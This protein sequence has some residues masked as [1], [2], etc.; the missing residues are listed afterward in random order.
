[1]SAKPGFGSKVTA[2]RVSALIL[3]LALACSSGA[4]TA[5]YTLDGGTAAFTNQTFASSLTNQSAV[6]VKNSGRL[7]LIDGIVTSSGNTT[8]TDASSQYGLNASLLVN[9]AGKVAM[10]G[11]SITSTG[12]GANLAFA[13]G[14]GS[15]ICLTHATLTATGQNAHAVDVTYG[16]VIV[17]SNVTMVTRGG[18]SSAIATDYG[19]GTVT[20]VNCQAT[21]SGTKSAAIYSTGLISAYNSVCIS[22]NDYGGVID[23][24][25]SIVLSNTVMTG[26]SGGIQIHR[27]APGTGTATVT[28]YG[29]SV[30]ATSGNSFDALGENAATLLNLTLRSGTQLSNSTGVILSVT[31][32]STVSFVA[33]G[34]TLAG[35]IVASAANTNTVY[36]S[37]QNGTALTGFINSAKRLTIDAT[38]TWHATSNSVVNVLTNS[39]TI[40]LSGSLTATNVI[41]KSG[42]VFGGSGTLS[43]NLTVNAG[44]TLV[45]NPATN[46]TVS[47]SVIFGG[48]V[49]V[50]PS[51][52]NISAG[53]YRLLTYHST[54]SGSPVFTY[55]A[56]GGSGQT[57]TVDTA[58]AGV[59]TVT[60][61]APNTH[62]TLAAVS[63]RVITAGARL[64][65][66]NVATDADIPAQTLT[67]GLIAAPTNATLDATSGVLA[68][69]PLISQAYTTN[70][71]AVCVADSGSPSLSATQSF[72]VVV[73][74][75]AQPTNAGVSFAAGACQIQICGNLGPDYIIQAASNLVNASWITIGTTNPASM[76]FVWTDLTTG[77]VPSRFYR[78]RLG[79]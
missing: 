48:A 53:T 1:M 16:G 78:V 14:S 61:S 54:L 25:N 70:T 57:A 15:A 34:E 75:A 26:K 56:P 63:N 74:A 65:V 67:F 20:V 38:S 30:T 10:T 72:T 55:S 79:P 40:N 28:V 43:S 76:P 46:F 73:S 31:N 22:S 19:G 44:A 69:R 71:F 51:A 6:L 59:I 3:T 68:W 49:T 21:V 52:T 50:A 27:T 9:S 64:S 77:N 17:A 8:N 4:Q 5:T 39:G 66:T 32:A 24:G 13:T 23:V 41:V 29:G 11:G 35:N 33:D 36:I 60:V 12:S 58:T 62:P 45:L 7:E 42:G 18:S 47:G 2:N 37:L